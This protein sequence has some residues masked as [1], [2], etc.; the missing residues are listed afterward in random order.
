MRE[1]DKN[2]RRERLQHAGADQVN[3]VIELV[4]NTFLARFACQRR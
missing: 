3:A 1:A 2:L 4:M